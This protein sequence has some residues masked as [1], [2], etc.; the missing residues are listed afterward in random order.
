MHQFLKHLIVSPSI[1]SSTGRADL[2]ETLRAGCWSL[3]VSLSNAD[4]IA[5]F[6]K[7]SD[8]GVIPV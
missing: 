7:R 3:A 4:F 1:S 8:G 6:C 5:R 2:I